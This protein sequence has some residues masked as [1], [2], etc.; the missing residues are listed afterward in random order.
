MDREN[1]YIND[2]HDDQNMI[3]EEI[4]AAKEN[5]ENP[6][7]EGNQGKTLEEILNNLLNNE[8]NQLDPEVMVQ[9]F[10]KV[11]LEFS[12]GTEFVG[13]MIEKIYEGKDFNPGP[14]RATID[15]STIFVYRC[16]DC[17]VM[18]NTLICSKCFENSSHIDHR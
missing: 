15:E 14:C 4:S 13:K 5:L 16:L 18:P 10:T 1:L 6:S 7:D 9:R 2:H 8:E 11:V 3:I 12:F 17:R